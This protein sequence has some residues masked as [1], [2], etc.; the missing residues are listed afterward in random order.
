MRDSHEESGGD[1][2]KGA[3]GP[4]SGDE[5][6][7]RPS[8]RA[9]TAASALLT[10]LTA[11]SLLAATVAVWVHEQVFD[12]ENF[13]EMI[14]PIFTDAAVTA[15]ISDAVAGEVIEALQLQLR[16]E[17]T[18]A[19]V[20]AFLVEGIADALELTDRQ[21]QAIARLPLPRL[22]DLAEPLAAGVELRIRGATDALVASE[23]FQERIPALVAA[24]HE[25]AVALVR[26]DY[27]QLP[28]LVIESGEVRLDLVP[29]VASTI[30]SLVAGGTVQ[31]DQPVPEIDPGVPVPQA[32]ARLSEALGVDLPDDFG[33]VVIMSQS[34]LEE[35]QATVRTLDRLVWV[36]IGL[37]VV[38]AVAAVMVSTRRRRALV[39]LG[40]ASG[41]ALLASILAIG[42]IERRILAAIAD[43]GAQEAAGVVVGRV[44]DDLRSTALI[45]IGTALIVALVAHLAGRPAWLERFRGRGGQPAEG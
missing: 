37:T 31:T 35:V 39:Y 23:A 25:R 32:I 42:A 9:R 16:F 4:R 41:L 17:E 26:E 36:L 34:E 19:G 22:T 43:P 21:R 27:E 13:M 14:D 7:R 5:R 6:L 8:I 2:A 12:T 1:E 30:R 10:I 33:Q 24:G 40:L 11:V 44:I 20:Q 38:L 18:L 29:L 28:N 45:V 15:A 3:S